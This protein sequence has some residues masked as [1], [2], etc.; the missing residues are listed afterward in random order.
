MEALWPPS[1]VRC[2][3]LHPLGKS[4]LLAKGPQLREAVQFQEGVEERWPHLWRPSSPLGKLGQSGYINKTYNILWGWGWGR[5]FLI[6]ENKESQLVTQKQRENETKKGE[7]LKEKR[8]KNQV[9][10]VT[11]IS[12]PK[13]T[14]LELN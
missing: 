3:V 2:T 5:C 6:P 13:S 7:C 14:T 4:P 9:R 10:S 8:K 1:P 11:C 12:P